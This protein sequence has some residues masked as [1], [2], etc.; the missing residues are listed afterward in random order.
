MVQMTTIQLST[1][2]PKDPIPVLSCKQK[3]GT[4]S[5]A[6]NVW[7]DAGLPPRRPK[8]CTY[9][10]TKKTMTVKWTTIKSDDSLEANTTP[11]ANIL[12]HKP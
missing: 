6:L 4:V 3:F 8:T 5:D 1:I 9:T 11:A 2:P 10:D 7:K 12:K